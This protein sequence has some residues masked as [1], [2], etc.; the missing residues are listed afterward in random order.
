MQMRFEELRERLLRA[1]VAPRHVRRYLREL[2]DH[3]ADLRA[4]EERAGRSPVEAERAALERLGSAEELERAM[5]EKP[6]LRA[7]SARA[8]WAVFG[9]APLTG[10]AGAYLMACLILWTG[11]RMFMPGL[12]SPFVRVDGLA[13]VYFGVGRMV[14]WGAPVAA[15]WAIGLLAARQRVKVAWPV[16]G[17]AVVALIGCM[18]QVHTIRPEF[19]GAWGQVSMR[20]AVGPTIEENLGRLV[21]ALGIFA[22]T[23]VPYVVW[24]VSRRT[25]S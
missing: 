1:G 16:V 5:L 24:R 15:G 20:L 13:V 22:W 9:I 4:E 25:A 23:A 19:P 18:A 3:V 8:P 10:L 21:Y 11:W 14:Y 2:R 7:W 12:E 6:Q 17:L